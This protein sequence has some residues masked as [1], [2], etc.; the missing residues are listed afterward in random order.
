MCFALDIETS[1]LD[2]AQNFVVCIGVASADGVQQF[3]APARDWNHNPWK[4]E[5]SILEAAEAL[6]YSTIPNKK[7]LVSFNG[8]SFDVP[9]L[10][11]R[12]DGYHLKGFLATMVGGG[13]PDRPTQHIDLMKFVKQCAGR[14]MAKDDAFH[15]FGDL[16]TPRNSSGAF[17]ARIYNSGVATD[18]EHLEM[19]QHNAID[20][21]STLRFFESMLRF[22]DFRAFYG[23]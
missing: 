1:G 9:F 12:L 4:A 17:T 18:V 22:P 3:S 6:V 20:C 7:F 2:P 13:T 23:L 16:Y 14:F 10:Q 11:N 19:L 8:E 15:K 5:K 21:C